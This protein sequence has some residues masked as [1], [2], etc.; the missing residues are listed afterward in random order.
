MESEPLEGR[1][2]VVIENIQPSVDAGRFPIKRTKSQHVEVT[3]DVFADGHD[4]VSC[5]LLH[6]GPGNADWQSTPLEALGNDAWRAQLDVDEL[7]L[8]E[9]TVEGWIDAF[10][11]WLRD[12]KKR[13]EAQQDVSVD[14]KIGSEL[15]QGALHRATAAMQKSKAAKAEVDELGQWKERL[16]DPK[17]NL[18]ELLAGGGDE[19]L[20]RLA[21]RYPDKSLATRFDTVFSVVVDRERARFSSWYEMF[22]RSASTEPGRHGTFRDVIAR[23]PYVQSMGFDVLYLPPIHP[24][25][26]SFRKGKNNALVAKP[27]EPGSPW[28]I[29]SSEGGHKAINPELGTAKDF[30]DLVAAAKKHDMEIALDIAFQCSPEHPYVREH[31][32]WFR[33]R[34]DGTI[35]YA[36]NPP[37][38]YQDIYPFDFETKA[39]RA[40]WEELASVFLHWAGEGV[41]I[42]RVDNPHTKAF[43]FWEWAISKVKADYPDTI[44]LSEA[45][46]RPKVM[47]RL[48]KLGFSQSYT[49]FTWRNHKHEF[50]EYFTE[51]TSTRLQE[52]FRPNLWPNT[53]DIL[54]DHL[55]TGAR[56][57]FVARVV[58]AGTLGANYGIY[59]PAFELM[60]HEP[61]EPGS[62]EYLNS[63]KYEIRTWDLDRKDSLQGTLRRLNAARQENPA[64]KANLDLV[65]H[66]I[67]NDRLLA[68]TKRS[69]EFKNLVLV[70]VN[71]DFHE[72]QAGYLTLPLAELG[73]NPDRPY[74]VRDALSGSEFRWE[75]ARNYVELDPQ[76]TPVHLMVVGQ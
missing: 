19:S 7:G 51:L 71:L 15:L 55:Q 24:V 3:A 44:F 73:L 39:W 16:A 30:R 65:F 9:Y 13:L 52:F 50:I 56:A 37:K 43:A 25:G 46:T 54:P 57:A 61:R 20:A 62:E 64:L 68:Y 11:S 32:E 40:L 69:R 29:G 8:Y 63:E 28:A 48:A 76:V 36:E 59:G 72:K 70:V 22:P 12:L 53:P 26:T 4:L 49:Y 1:R 18:T 47:Y 31:P 45:F 33:K 67:D 42:F 38:K 34:P 75:G 21:G 74:T 10:G 35:Q 41:R 2:R 27:G 23:L 6:R 60:E 58:M 17:T 66:P 14:R 5:A